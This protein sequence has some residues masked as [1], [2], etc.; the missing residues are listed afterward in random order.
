MSLNQYEVTKCDDCPFMVDV[1]DELYGVV[2]Y[3]QCN[4]YDDGLRFID[5]INSTPDWCPLLKDT[6]IEVSHVDN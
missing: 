1:R 4:I 3:H 6:V 2:Q 5:D